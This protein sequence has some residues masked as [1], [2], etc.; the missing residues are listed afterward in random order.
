MV[1]LGIDPGISGAICVESDSQLY[2]FDMPIIKRGKKNVICGSALKKLFLDWI[3]DQ[4]IYHVGLEDVHVR[5]HFKKNKKGE[6]EKQ[7][8]GSVS[9]FNFG[10][11][12]GIIEG[13]LIGLEIPY[14]FITPQSWKKHFLDGMPKEKDSSRI[15]ALQLL[16]QHADEFKLKKSHGKADAYFILQELNRRL[17]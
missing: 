7:S 11:G 16:P 9:S 1:L 4:D 14:T 13:I 17:F 15:R 5:P 2:F 12:Y 8:E 6:L 3:E 10:K